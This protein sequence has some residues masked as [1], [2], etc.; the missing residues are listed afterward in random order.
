MNFKVECGVMKVGN[1]IVMVLP[2]IICK[3][4]GIKVTKKKMKLTVYINDNGIIIP[5]KTIY[6]DKGKK[7]K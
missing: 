2:Q 4:Y 3:N 7:R 6:D 5:K 1:S